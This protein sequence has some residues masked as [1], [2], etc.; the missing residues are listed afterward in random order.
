MRLTHENSP[1]ARAKMN[2]KRLLLIGV[3]WGLGTA[4]GLAILVGI[5]LWYE[6]RPKPPVPP[7]PWNSTSIKADYDYAYTEGDGNNIVVYY[8]LENMS[9]FDY[10]VED[11]H[12]MT[13]GAKLKKE[14]SLSPFNETGK[15]D[16]PIFVPAKK[17]VRFPIHLSYPYPV[18]ENPKAD[19]D[20][21]K[22]YRQ[23]VE[24]YL[25]DELGNLDGFDL[26]DETS[27]YEIIFPN[28]WTRS[29]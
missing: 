6:G 18:K 2:W 7:K 8:T 14:S 19:V 12:N 21:R 25:S 23:A 22:K 29:Q 13:I 15:I 1:E 10:R 3:G 16:Y 27:R 9:D 4:F 20:E 17:R 11:G 28:G 5:F 24:K 26:L